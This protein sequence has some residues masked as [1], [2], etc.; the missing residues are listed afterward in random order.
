[1]LY[2]Y[3]YI[4]PGGRRATILV[5]L[6]PILV[7]RWSKTSIWR[8]LLEPLLQ[9]SAHRWWRYDGQRNQF[10]GNH[11]SHYFGCFTCLGIGGVFWSHYFT[12]PSTGGSLFG[13]IVGGETNLAAFVGSTI[14]AVQPSDLHHKRLHWPSLRCW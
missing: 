13:S 1:M 10:A 6:S 12:N 5:V 14:S 11:Q 8:R 2:I 7:V 3:I 9:Q 4:Y